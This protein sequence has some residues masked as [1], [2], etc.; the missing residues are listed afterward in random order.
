[1]PK[2]QPAL[3]PER[4]TRPCRTP[5]CNRR[6]DWPSNPEVLAAY[7]RDC[8][9][10]VMHNAHASSRPAAATDPSFAAGSAS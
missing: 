3:E 10:E 4:L 7:C 8:T 1:M 2:P 6:T 9:D 5:D